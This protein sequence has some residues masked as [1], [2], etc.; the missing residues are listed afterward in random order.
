[1]LALHL[2]RQQMIM[3]AIGLVVSACLTLALVPLL[4]AQGAALAFVGGE[5]VFI[6]CAFLFLRSA[7]SDI[8]FSPRVPVRVVLAAALASLLVLVP[9]LSSLPT[10][11][12]A[13]CVYVGVL[14]ATGAIPD[15]LKHA[16]TERFQ[17]KP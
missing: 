4:A 7:S 6:T 8:R 9:G 15:E 12:L 11:L 1:M 16:V 10:A 2:H 14:A 5:L 13:I 3:G 17:A